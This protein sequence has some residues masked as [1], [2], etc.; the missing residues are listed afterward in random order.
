MGQEE[1]FW[2]MDF[3]LSFKVKLK[4]EC[5]VIPSMTIFISPL[6]HIK[7]MKSP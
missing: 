3:P 6:S 4:A 2:Q 5:C 7:I 1:G